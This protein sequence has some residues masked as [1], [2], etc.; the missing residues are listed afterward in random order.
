MTGIQEDVSV[1]SYRV[2]GVTM[3]SR[4]IALAMAEMLFKKFYGE[5]D[6]K[7]QLPL[8]VTDGGDHWSIEGSRNGDDHP[9]EEGQTHFGRTLIVILKANCQ[10]MRLTQ[11]MY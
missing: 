1:L 2:A 10:V 3:A 5:D 7:T 6:F 9:V 8:K 11:S 4:E